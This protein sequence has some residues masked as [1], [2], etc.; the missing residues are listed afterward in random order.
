M[1]NIIYYSGIMGVAV[2]NMPNGEFKFHGH[3]KYFDDT[4]WGRKSGNQF[5]FDPGVL[6]DSGKIYLYS[7]FA[8]KIPFFNNRF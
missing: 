3:V 1:E 8:E 7:G 5:L 2:S 6:V 4:L